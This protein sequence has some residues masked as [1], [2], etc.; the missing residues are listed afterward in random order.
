MTSEELR[1]FFS[2]CDDHLRR[3]YMAIL[4]TG[5]R[6]GEAEYLTWED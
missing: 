5:M 2:T 3:L 6:K 1:R 4:L